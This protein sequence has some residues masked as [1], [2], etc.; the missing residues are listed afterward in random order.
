MN[1]KRRIIEVKPLKSDD[2]Y[3]IATLGCMHTV[4]MQRSYFDYCKDEYM[5]CTECTEKSERK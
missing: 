5:I 4:E 2:R 1:Q 3:V